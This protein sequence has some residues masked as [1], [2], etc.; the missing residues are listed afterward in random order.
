MFLLSFVSNSA[1]E[2]KHELSSLKEFHVIA[3]A[4]WCGHCKALAPEYAKA[5]TQLAEEKSEVLLAKIDATQEGELAEKF[6][7]RGYPTIKFF[8][9]G[10]HTEYGG[11]RSSEDILKWI[12]K[13]TGPAAKT[14]T[15]VDEAKEFKTSANV[16]IA[17]L[18]SDV[19]S[20]PAKAFLEVAAENDEFPFAIIS[21]SAVWTEL[22]SKTEGVIL[23]KTFDEGRNQLEEE[24]TVDSIKK[25]ISSNSLPLVVEFSQET[26]QKIFGGEIKAHNLLFLSRKSSEYETMVNEFKSVA[27]E[28]KGKVLFV[29]IDTDVEDHE[30]IMEFFG[31]K[32][33]ES[34]EMRLIKLEDEMTKFKP[35]SSDIKADNIRTFVQKV[36]DGK[37]KVCLSKSA[38]CFQI[39]C[40][41]IKHNLMIASVSYL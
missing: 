2:S 7:V 35:E 13:K 4:P 5:A 25:F 39:V 18:F 24:V 12:K 32:K 10:K 31:L 36:L 26:A 11:G 41:L 17:G 37:L 40:V 16:V 30:R 21:D 6:E 22:E 28:F 15:T 9:N 20:A 34:P 29:T 1:L 38:N 19:E 14:L 27:K 8:R 23:Y 3:D 33:T